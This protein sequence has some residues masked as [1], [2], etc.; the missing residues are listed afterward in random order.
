MVFVFKLSS[1][2]LEWVGEE[3]MIGPSA[4]KKEKLKLWS[5]PQNRRFYGKMKFLPLW[6]HLFR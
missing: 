6:P 1:F 4:K 5:L 3:R 2:S